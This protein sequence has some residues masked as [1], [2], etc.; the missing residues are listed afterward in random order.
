V[1][2]REF[3]DGQPFASRATKEWLKTAS[4]GTSGSAAVGASD[5]GGSGVFEQALTEAHQLA[6]GGRLDAAVKRLTEIVESEAVGGRDRFRAKLA[7]ADACAASG[8]PALAEGI[9]AA[10]DSQIEQFRLEEWE[11][12]MAEACYRSR[13]EVLAAMAGESAKSRDELVDVYRR[14]CAVAP[15]AALELGKPPR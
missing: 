10:L 14:L 3:S 4:P 1:L 2:E 9:L 6:I 15:A 12:K 5:G 11:P 8:A 13:Y 7:M